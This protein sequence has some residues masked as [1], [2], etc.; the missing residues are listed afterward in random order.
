MKYEKC[1][2]RQ[3]KETAEIVFQVSIDIIINIFN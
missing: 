3:P 1:K 2:P